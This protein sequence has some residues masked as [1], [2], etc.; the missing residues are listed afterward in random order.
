MSTQISLQELEQVIKNLLTH[1]KGQAGSD[2]IG[3][4][5]DYYWNVPLGSL[6]DLSL[7]EEDISKQIGVGS[8]SD[9]WESIRALLKKDP[10][11]VALSLLKV[12]PL[13]CY[14]AG[15]IQEGGTPPREKS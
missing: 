7:P 14:L 2:T 3:L 1:I 12:A 6:Y 13:L 9:D 15:A 5:K 8:L 10:E 11:P 4:E